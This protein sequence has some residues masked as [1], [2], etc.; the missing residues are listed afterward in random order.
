MS[1]FKVTKEKHGIYVEHPMLIQ[2]S[3]EEDYYGVPEI[4]IILPEPQCL[5]GQLSREVYEKIGTVNFRTERIIVSWLESRK[6]NQSGQFKFETFVQKVENYARSVIE[7]TCRNL[8]NLLRSHNFKPTTINLVDFLRRDGLQTE[9]KEKNLIGY[10]YT[11]YFEGTI[12]FD[13]PLT[14]LDSKTFVFAQLERELTGRVPHEIRK[15]MERLLDEADMRG[16]YS[17]IIYTTSWIIW[18]KSQDYYLFYRQPLLWKFKARFQKSDSQQ[19]KKLFE[20]SLKKTDVF[21]ILQ[22]L[23][24]IIPMLE[25]ET[26]FYV[27]FRGNWDPPQRTGDPLSVLVRIVNELRE[28]VKSRGGV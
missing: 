22:D 24:I 28:L 19:V 10:K 16:A 2:I 15:F 25:A 18:I 1:N 6:P 8:E 21:D 17:Y 13:P 9:K 23:L 5:E 20:N 12:S 27:Y 7:E 4:E 3:F 14:D 11:V 26:E